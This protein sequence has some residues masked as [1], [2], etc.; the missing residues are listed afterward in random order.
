VI[1]NAQVSLQYLSGNIQRKCSYHEREREGSAVLIFFCALNQF[2]PHVWQ[3]DFD[4]RN[5]TLKKGSHVF[6]TQFIFS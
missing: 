5:S 2:E 4:G 3:K 6:K 1:E